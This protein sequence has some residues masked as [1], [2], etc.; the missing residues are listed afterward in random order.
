MLSLAR[1]GYVAAGRQFAA[2][3]LI[4]LAVVTL[5]EI[6]MVGAGHPM[7]AFHTESQLSLFFAYADI[8]AAIA[9][10]STCNQS[11]LQTADAL[12]H[13]SRLM[14]PTDPS[15]AADILQSLLWITAAGFA[16]MTVKPP[17]SALAGICNEIGLCWG[18]RA[19][20]PGVM[21][22]CMAAFGANARAATRASRGQD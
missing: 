8:L 3:L 15:R 12:R 9:V 21:S 5:I 2:V 20:W 13:A 17:P 6:R 1:A 11:I 19:G 7:E 4:A 14:Y 18:V 10:I 22:I 16:I